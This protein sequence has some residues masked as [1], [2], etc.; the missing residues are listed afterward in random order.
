MKE[1]KEITDLGFVAALVTL[2][3]EPVETF[4]QGI[5]VVFTFEWDENMKDL[6]EKYFSNSLVGTKPGEDYRSFI[7]NHRDLKKAIYSME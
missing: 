6:E 3:Y 7:I 5:R 1:R 4:K 2:G